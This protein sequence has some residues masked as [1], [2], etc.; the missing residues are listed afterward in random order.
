M[1]FAP[2]R[3]ASRFELSSAPVVS[4]HIPC[5]QTRSTLSRERSQSRWSPPA[6]ASESNGLLKYGA[7]QREV[8]RVEGAEADAERRDLPRPAAV[9]V[10]P[11]HHL[12]EDPGLVA[13]VRTGALLERQIAVRPRRA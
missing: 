5:P 7:A 6:L 9:L 2:S 3:S 1:P 11:R 8:D 4:S 10:D 13:A 12:V